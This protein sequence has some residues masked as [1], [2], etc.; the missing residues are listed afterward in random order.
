MGNYIV[1]C[2]ILMLT[3]L[4]HPRVARASRDINGIQGHENKF[5]FSKSI[6]S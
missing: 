1:F 6:A 2:F 5:E 4:L 3:L